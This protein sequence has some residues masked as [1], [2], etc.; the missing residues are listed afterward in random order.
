MCIWLRDI[1][2]A[3]SPA[4]PA[5]DLIIAECGISALH[6]HRTFLLFVYFLFLFFLSSSFFLK[7][8]LLFCV[9]RLCGFV[10][11]DQLECRRSGD[12]F[13]ALAGRVIT[14]PYILAC[15]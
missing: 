2:K 3:G 10:V 12:G 8:F 4:L 13:L 14:A 6:G 5:Y 9:N 15:E 1:L 7:P 11:R